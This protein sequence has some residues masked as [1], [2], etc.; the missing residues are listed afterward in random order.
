MREADNA[1]ILA[2]NDYGYQYVR[3]SVHRTKKTETYDNASS[4]ISPM[5]F[6]MRIVFL[7][8]TRS[9]KTNLASFPPHFRAPYATKRLCMNWIRFSEIFGVMQKVGALKNI[10]GLTCEERQSSNWLPTILAKKNIGEMFLRISAKNHSESY[11]QKFLRY[12]L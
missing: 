8:L 11:P 6:L 3:N 10:M 9:F 12:F 7:L 4:H 1:F 2:D 5:L